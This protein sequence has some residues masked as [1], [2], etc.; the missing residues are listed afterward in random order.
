MK[1]RLLAAA[2]A[3]LSWSLPDT[4]QAQTR[5]TVMDNFRGSYV[6]TQSVC[7]HRRRGTCVSWA[8]RRVPVFPNMSHTTRSYGGA[9]SPK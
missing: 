7:I 5:R 4:L 2:V 1:M 3:A 9:T 8:H 6:T